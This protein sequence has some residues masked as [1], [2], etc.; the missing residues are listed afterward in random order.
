MERFARALQAAASRAPMLSVVRFLSINA[1]D[2]EI[3]L[4][5]G[6]WV[7]SALAEPLVHVQFRQAPCHNR[8]SMTRF[9]V[10]RPPSYVASTESVSSPLGELWLHAACCLRG[11]HRV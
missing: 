4:N 8:E 3:E 2:V 6:S 1:I 10:V 7:K 5:Q 9:P 11:V